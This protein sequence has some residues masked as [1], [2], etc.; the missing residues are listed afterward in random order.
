MY[1]PPRADPFPPQRWAAL[2]RGALLAP[3]EPL[4]VALS[5]GVGSSALLALAALA[6][7]KPGLSAV[8]VRQDPE[9]TE[10]ARQLA[11]ELA[12][13]LALLPAA[14]D[15]LLAAARWARSQARPT[16]LA[17]DC[18]LVGTVERRPS[19]VVPAAREHRE[20]VA[21]ARP[22]RCLPRGEL[23]A[24]LR[25]VSLPFVDELDAAALRIVADGVQA[26]LVGGREI[27]RLDGQLSQATAALVWDPPVHCA[28][29]RGVADAFVGGCVD[30][31]ALMALPRA[32][33]RRALWRLL[34]EALGRELAPTQ[35]E[36]ALELLSRGRTGRLAIEPGF[37]LVM[38]ADRLHLEPLPPR[39]GHD[40]RQLVLPFDSALPPSLG[41]PL[42]L[43]GEVRLDDGRSIRAS[44]LELAAACA[45]LSRQLSVELD[46]SRLPDRLSVR[47]PRAGDRFHPLGWPQEA[48]LASFLAASGVPREG[49]ARVPIVLAEERVV[50]V[51]GLRPAE[52]VRVASGTRRRVRLDLV[53]PL[54]SE[55][56]AAGSRR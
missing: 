56:G 6:R 24:A 9:S 36:S 39:R 5:G 42:V 44:L 55:E 46:A 45:P 25:L 22:L 29:R 10:V 43:P 52:S 30:R 32:L 23:A 15:P 18:R 41:A 49:R 16:L 28:A 31:G 2:A 35:V 19:A 37:V 50:W 51:A 53:H 38:R 54:L 3:E 47:F 40:P 26:T 13:P 27:L 11:S 7:P 33:R 34:H 12:V 17:G 14:E 8:H 48:S 20:G 21:I 4:V 1:Q